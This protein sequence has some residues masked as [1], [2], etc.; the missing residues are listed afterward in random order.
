MTTQ[1]ALPAPPVC[2]NYKCNKCRYGT[3]KARQFLFHQKAVHGENINIYACDLCEYA[4]RHKNK[5]FRHRKLVHK[6]AD[7]LNE[8][9]DIS[10]NIEETFLTE[11]EQEDFD[12]AETFSEKDN[13][14][15]ADFLSPSNSDNGTIEEDVVNEMEAD[16]EEDDEISFR[17]YSAV[18]EEDSLI[19][20]EDGSP[21]M[22]EST[23]GPDPTEDAYT[24]IIAEANNNDEV[25][26][27]CKLC[28]YRNPHKWKIANHIRSIHMRRKLFKCPYC[29]FVCERKIEWCVHKTSHTNKVVYSCDECAYRTTMKRNFERHQSRHNTKGPFK[30]GICSYSSTGEAAIQR[31]MAEYH[32]G[33]DKDYS[34]LN[35]DGS[36]TKVVRCATPDSIEDRP[37]T[38]KSELDGSDSGEEKKTGN[39][40]GG[41]IC[42]LCGIVC[43]TEAR[44]RIHMI[45]HSSTT[46]WACSYCPLRYKRAADLNRHVRRKHGQD[47]KAD[48]IVDEED[49]TNQEQPLDLCVK[50]SPC[51]SSDEDQPLDLSVK[52]G[53][54]FRGMMFKTE[55]LKCSHCSYLA[56]WPSDL[57]RHMLVHSIEKRFRCQYCNKRYKYQFDLNMHIRKA[58]RLPAGRTRVSSSLSTS[59]SLEDDL[60]ELGE[61]AS[62]FNPLEGSPTMVPQRRAWE[63]KSQSPVIITPSKQSN[64]S[65]NLHCNFCSYVGKY[66]AEV[67][68]HMRLHTGQKPY[69]CLFCTYQSFWKGDMKRHLVKH[70][71]DEVEN[72]GEGKDEL[73]ELVNK[74]LVV[75]NSIQNKDKPVITEVTNDDEDDE[76]EMIPD[77]GEEEIVKVEPLDPEEHPIH[78]YLEENNNELDM[79]SGY[80]NNNSIGDISLSALSFSSPEFDANGNQISADKKIYR[81]PQCPF[82]CEAPSKL[83]CHV[84]IHGNLKRYMCPTCGKRSN[85]LWDV[86][87]HIRKDHPGATMDVTEL[88]ETDARNTLEEYLATHRSPAKSTRETPTRD[89]PSP[90]MSPRTF[91]RESTP[92]VEPIKVTEVTTG[93]PEK[94][95]ATQRC[96]PFKC[97]SCG[98]RSNWKWDLNKHI[99]SQCPDAELIILSP[100]EARATYNE[101]V[102]Q[103]QE[104][105]KAV[106]EVDVLPEVFKPL[107]P[108]SLQPIDLAKLSQERCR[109]YQ[110]SKCGRRSNWKWDMNKHIRSLHSG[111]TL[112][113]LN[114]DEARSTIDDYLREQQ[115]SQTVLQRKVQL[116]RFSRQRDDERVMLHNYTQLQNENNNYVVDEVKQFQIITDIRP[117][118]AAPQHVDLQKLKRFKCSSCPYR[119]NFR[120][121]ISRHIKRKH[122][123]GE[124]SITLL[125]YSEASSTLNEYKEV[126][127]RK[128]FVPSPT[129]SVSSGVSSIASLESTPSKPLEPSDSFPKLPSYDRGKTWKCTAC[130]FTH[131][132][133]TFVVKHYKKHSGAAFVCR[134]CGETSGY[135]G[136]MYRH[137]RKKHKRKDFDK[138][139]LIAAIELVEGD[140]VK[141]ES[142][143]AA[144]KSEYDYDPG[145][146]TYKPKHYVCKICTSS[147]VYRGTVV[148]H[149]KEK[150]GV[151]LNYEQFIAEEDKPVE[152]RNR[153]VEDAGKG[154]KCDICP[155]RTNKSGLLKI[156]KSYHKPQPGNKMKC[157]YCPYYVC[158]TRLLH[159]HVRLHLKERGI[160][161]NGP[162]S[163]DQVRGDVSTAAESSSQAVVRIIQ[164]SKPGRAKHFCDRCPYVS[165]NRN[166]YLYH[167]QFHRPKPTAPF[168]CEYCP[169]WVSLRRLLTQHQKVH[170]A[171]YHER[172]T[173]RTAKSLLSPNKSKLPD[174]E[175]MSEVNT[176]QTAHVK[177]RIIASKITSVPVTPEKY[178]PG[179]VDGTVDET[180]A[181]G[182]PASM[183]SYVVNKS[184]H[185]LSTGAYRKLHKC[186][187]CP[188]T[189]VRAT[190]LRLHEKM[191]GFRHGNLVK[192]PFCDYYVGNKGLLSHHMKVHS[193][194]YKPGDIINDIEQE[195]DA[196]SEG[197]VQ[198]ENEENVDE[199]G[200]KRPRSADL[201]LPPPDRKTYPPDPATQLSA[202]AF[203]E[204]SGY[205]IKYDENTGEHI[206]ERAVFKKW[207]CEKCPY[208]TM[209][210]AQFE[211]HALLHG[212]KQKYTCEFCDYSVP[213]YHLLL[214]HKRLHLLPNPNLLSVQSISNLQ[215]LPEVPAD[216]AAATNYTADD[217]ESDF[218]VHDHLS[219]YENA[220]DF[221]EPKKLYKCDRCPYTNVRRDHLLAH[222]K[223]HMLRSDLQC[224]YCDYSVSKIHLLNQHLKVHFNSSTEDGDDNPSESRDNVSSAVTKPTD[225]PEFIDISELGKTIHKDKP[226]NSHEVDINCND[227]KM[228][229][230]EEVDENDNTKPVDLVM[231]PSVE[232][233]KTP[234]TDDAKKNGNIE[235][236]TRISGDAVPQDLSVRK[237]HA[238]TAPPGESE[239]KRPNSG[240]PGAAGTWL[241]QYCERGFTASD[242]LLRHEMQHLVGTN[243]S[244]T[245]LTG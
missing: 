60:A 203:P 127:A 178:T 68:R 133:K 82:I 136:S 232:T 20:D 210:R 155:Y 63:T 146:N 90:Q 15:Y 5:V 104:P 73:R 193:H 220:E 231:K 121:D 165:I 164:E 229:I 45:A 19:I 85:W 173:S 74:T 96:R 77:E 70:H 46:P 161:Q 175:T 160:P 132:N 198:E 37:E 113:I 61:E 190:N 148:R 65:S 31:H 89:I 139:V 69:A 182:E 56:K 36:P 54:L 214:Q 44:L 226:I 118:N 25:V 34:T 93:S 240:A 98:K 144:Y 135:R 11:D 195:E 186:K 209:K 4:S 24:Y 138:A 124:S 18:T 108:V 216:V 81:C 187:D 40:S 78:S 222:L 243:L 48:M 23:N 27:R 149:L 157:K 183:T 207:C 153:Q 67:E 71:P 42:S 62:H 185:L 64:D 130:D 59:R 123:D 29:P 137:V 163:E 235:K 1:K 211:R 218:G 21:E 169:Y 241:C 150:H 86:R 244:T 208:A 16:F 58:H 140:N 179:P 242:K 238:T 237:R 102:V 221:S 154:L 79:C 9:E 206:L 107:A 159:Q 43:K 80:D 88:S 84:E 38:A 3:S 166:D 170:T 162:L 224:P 230:V 129:K 109:P 167:K 184:G 53:G 92:I 200:V 239:S 228:E 57:R 152:P 126:W 204:K 115:E 105:P 125:S 156:H 32:P 110:C 8:L 91:S 75:S 119:S 213:G 145:L 106:K 199:D 66:K 189:N 10:S 225:Q 128:K 103:K 72:C 177:Q 151:I 47:G 233:K 174:L 2:R 217:V 35:M 83:K 171:E 112:I 212:S 192:C 215:Q 188:Y 76:E 39:N 205:Y 131:P 141:S 13:S 172:S 50:R 116:E 122:L 236:M 142:S 202:N 197:A 7:E 117:K 180:L 99:R 176:I 223:F 55:N 168:K 234:V 49:I 100:V 87:K 12:A 95:P 158:A 41:A 194:Q 52:N 97:S 6:D 30:C 94:V 120:S 101:E 201:S 14:E 114:E 245:N 33:P 134:V 227:K 191:H 219:L 22:I 143:P 196:K 51:T 147:S 28:T 26:F 111:A 17:D 181:S